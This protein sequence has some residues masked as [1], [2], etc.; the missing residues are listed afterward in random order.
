VTTRGTG[1]SRGAAALCVAVVLA[2]ATAACGSSSEPVDKGGFSSKDRAQAQTA[3]NTIKGTS[4]PGT[5]VQLTATI[6]LPIVCR[7][8]FA[9]NDRKTLQLIMSWKPI[10]RSG[11]AFTWFSASLRSTGIVPNSMHLGTADTLK[12]IESKYGPA[13]TRPFEPCQINAFG[14]LTAVPWTGAYPKTGH[15]QVKPEG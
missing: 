12:A 15:A 13:Y 1:W 3:L 6:G 14:Y 8:H 2:A 5:I 9:N 7:V 10:P 11:N 4:V